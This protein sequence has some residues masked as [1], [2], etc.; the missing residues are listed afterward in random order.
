MPVVL[1][2]KCSFLDGMFWSKKFLN[3]LNFVCRF[4]CPFVWKENLLRS[5]FCH[6]TSRCYFC[7]T[8]WT[9]CYKSQ[10]KLH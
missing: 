9:W 8:Y 10:G 7:D 6:R 4:F 2:Q 5:A 1:R 3:S